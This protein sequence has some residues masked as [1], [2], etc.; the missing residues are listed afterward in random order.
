M[1]HIPKKLYVFREESNYR[2]R[3]LQVYYK[4]AVLK[5]FAQFAGKYVQKQPPELFCKKS[6]CLKFRNIH[7]KTPVLEAFKPTA[8]LK[9]E[10]N[11]GFFLWILRNFK[12]TYFEGHLRTA[13]FVPLP[14][15]LS[16]EILVLQPANFPNKDSEIGIFLWV[17]WKKIIQFFCGTSPYIA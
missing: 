7:R 11:T 1:P 13:A 6:C 3:R 10:S 2:I 9:K 14:D 8:L 5:I 17:L 4:K 15:F 12:K 16:N